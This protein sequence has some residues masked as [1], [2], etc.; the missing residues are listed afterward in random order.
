MSAGRQRRNS[1]AA[2]SDAASEDSKVPVATKKPRKQK[3]AERSQFSPGLPVFIIVAILLGIFV[4]QQTSTT[5]PAASPLAKNSNLAQSKPENAAGKEDVVLA[6]VD[7]EVVMMPGTE[8]PSVQ[9]RGLVSLNVD[10]SS[11]LAVRFRGS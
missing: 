9:E 8:T 7:K 3:G 4:W 11:V 5:S 1:Q 10:W 6:K 2:K